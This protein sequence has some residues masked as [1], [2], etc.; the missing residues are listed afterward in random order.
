MARPEIYTPEIAAHICEQIAT[1]TKSLRTICYEENMPSVG[2]VLKWM[3]DDKNGFLAQYARAKESQA[4]MMADEM[5]DIADETNHDTITTE[6]GREIQNSEWINR[7]RLRVDT[8]KWIASK[9]KPKKY[10]DRITQELTGADGG[11]I[12]ITGMEIVSY[13]KPNDEKIITDP[14]AANTDGVM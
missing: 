4:D 6:D 2:T 9:L 13:K 3:N 12:H 10:G 5:I 14:G 11:P 7:S 8:R 1:T